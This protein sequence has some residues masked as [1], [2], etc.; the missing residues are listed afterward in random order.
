MFKN[1][2]LFLTYHY[3]NQ[4]ANVPLCDPEAHL[5]SPPSTKVNHINTSTFDITTETSCGLGDITFKSVICPGGE[6]EVPDFLV[7]AEE[8]IVLPK[9]QAIDNMHETEDTVISD[10]TI[11][12]SCGDHNE[13]PYYN[14]E[15]K[16]ASLVDI[17]AAS[18]WEMSNTTLASG[19]LDNQQATQDFSAF[20]NEYCGKE[21]VTWKSFLCDG[22]EVE[23]FD[24]TRIQDETIPLPKAQLV[25]LVQENSVHLTCLSDCGQLSEAEHAEH[26]DH[27]Y[28]S[29]EST[30][31]ATTTFSDATNGSEKPADGLSDV[32]FKSLDCTGGEI[33]ISDGTTLADDTVPLPA[34]QSATCGESSNY[35]IDPS[36][37]AR[38]QD[39][40]SSND[41]FDHHYCNIENDLLKEPSSFS[42]DIE[43]EVKQISLVGPDS[44]T[45]R[46][47]GIPFSSFS[48]ARSDVIISD[49]LSQK[50]SP[51]LEQAVICHPLN[52][53]SVPSCVMRENTQEDHLH[54]NNRVENNEV[55]VDTDPPAIGTSSLP[56]TPLKALDDKSVS[57]Q[58]QEITKKDSIE[59]SALPSMLYRTESSDCC[60]LATSPEMP[61]SVEVHEEHVSQVQI[62]SES[63]EAVDSALG[64]SGNGPV[65]YNSAESLQAEHL[66]GIFKVLSECPSG[67]SSFP[68]GILSPVVRRASLAA[69]KAFRAPALDT[70]ALEGEKSAFAPFNVDPAGFW[71]EHMGSP[72]PRPLFN[73]TALGCKPQSEP[74]GDV[75]ATPWI[76]PHSEV[77]KPVLD[78]PLIPDG[79]LQQQ[80]QQMAEFLFLALGKMAPAAISVPILPPAAA[81]VPAAKDTSA[82]SHSVCVGT[83]LVKW[84]DQSVNTS[85]QFERKR[86]ISLVDSCTLTDPL[87]WK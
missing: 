2:N 63:N 8:S 80:L 33:E 31:Y 68:F 11:V 17:D 9:D 76:V 23:V 7:C 74:V 4:Q 6:V 24:V 53:E 64:L 25:E 58:M 16:D 85:G 77:E 39:W 54:P 48:S 41:H 26:A 18:L 1:N 86:N 62:G 72:L 60:H 20:P 12:Q 69:L 66:P 65:L 5:Q 49:G 14:L 83:T 78:I 10:S 84:L 70:Y 79:P 81:M 59:D 29:S 38:D 42:L 35:G 82:E 15:I 32:T 45:G 71:A 19:D 52:V 30:L 55:V 73:S 27:P 47:E 46:Q 3:S 56:Y 13:H 87:L 61:T 50:T 43:E 57:C 67:V 75:L 22:S 51:L 36:M 28:F 21:D 40:K 37:F 34:D 44:Q